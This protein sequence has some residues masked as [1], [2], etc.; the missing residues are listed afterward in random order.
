MYGMTTARFS[1]AARAKAASIRVPAV[2]VIASAP[3]RPGRAAAGSSPFLH[4][5][6]ET[7]HVLVSPPR[8]ADHDL[9]ARPGPRRLAP[10][11][12]QGMR[13]LQRR[14]DSGQTAELTERL[15]RL[16]VGDAFIPHAPGVLEPG[17][18]GT[19]AG[20]VESRRD[21]V[22]QLHLAVSVLEAIGPG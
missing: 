21:R 6:G 9:A 20:I 15:E 19:D 2:S 4:D 17:V 22:G 3:R 10:H 14:N 8:T 5:L 16:A 7:R 12:G 1:R 11:P 13:G 18:L